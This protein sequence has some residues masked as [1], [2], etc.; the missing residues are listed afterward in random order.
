MEK[1]FGVTVAFRQLLEEFST[2]DTLAAHVELR[3]NRRRQGLVASPNLEIAEA[4]PA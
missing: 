3:K 2:L 1:E 4:P